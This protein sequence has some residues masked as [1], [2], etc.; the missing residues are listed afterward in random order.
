MGQSRQR[1]RPVLR[2]GGRSASGVSR[3]GRKEVLQLKESDG[4]SWYSKDSATK[5]TSYGRAGHKAFQSISGLVGNKDQGSNKGLPKHAEVSRQKQR[6]LMLEQ[7][8]R[9]GQ[10]QG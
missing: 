5:T 10:V 4:S 2:T 7:T 8:G 9:S 6:A 3:G 1:T